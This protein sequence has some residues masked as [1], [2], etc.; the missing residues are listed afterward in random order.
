VL[1]AAAHLHLKGHKTTL[2][3]HPQKWTI[4]K[5]CKNNLVGYFE[6]NLHKYTLGTSDT[7]FTAC[8]KGHYTTP[9]PFEQYV[10]C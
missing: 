7:Y 8:E 2:F 9:L 4:L 1:E 5:C 10:I 6:V 3:S